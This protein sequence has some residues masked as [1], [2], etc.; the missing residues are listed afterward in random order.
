MTP[1]V[2]RLNGFV[3]LAFV[4]GGAAGLAAQTGFSRVVLQD[5][6]LGT[7][8]RHGVTARA[9]FAPGASAGVHV[10]PGE[11]FGFI[12]EGTVALS[13]EGRPTVALKEGDVFFIA[14]GVPHDGRNVGTVK[15]AIL[16]VFVAEEGK[17]LAT[18]VLAGATSNPAT[19]D[20]RR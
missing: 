10:H 19:P 13:V 3:V 17:P 16:S 9:E 4:A 5:H 8:G 14:A 12:L 1:R 15:A 18:P 2:V 11:E 6:P 7:A 20:V